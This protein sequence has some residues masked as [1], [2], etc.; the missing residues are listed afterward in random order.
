M[1][2]LERERGPFTDWDNPE[3][4]D[5]PDGYY[6][7]DDDGSYVP[8]PDDADFDLS[9]EA[10]YSGWEPSRHGGLLPQWVVAAGSV[11]VIVALVLSVI[12]FG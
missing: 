8:G 9:E 1:S 11:L 3:D 10:G 6:D 5:A 12:R 7:E 4:E 2:D